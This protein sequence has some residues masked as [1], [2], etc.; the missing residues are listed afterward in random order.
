MTD[1]GDTLSKAIELNKEKSKTDINNLIWKYKNG[2][3]KRL[4]DMNQ[5]ELQKALEHCDSMLYS[6]SRSTPGKYTIKKILKRTY[7]NINAE[8]FMR[9]VLYELNIDTLKTNKDLFD[10][11]NINKSQRNLKDSDSIT[12]LFNGVPTIFEKVT[13]DRLLSACFDKLDALNRNIIS[14]KFIISQGIWLTN[15]EKEELTEYDN[16]GKLRDRMEVIKERLILNNIKLRIDWKGLNYAEFRSL[17]KLDSCPRI[18]SLPTSTLKLL[19]DKI[20]LLLDYDL[21]YHINKWEELKSNLY[22]VSD[23]KGYIISIPDSNENPK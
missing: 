1:F 21:N 12:T 11:I 23:K 7:E 19:R 2:T 20:L 5:E 16:E 14:N 18:S 10:F 4:M 13:I 3:T 15:Q 22:K 8:L 6:T 9:Y 17:I